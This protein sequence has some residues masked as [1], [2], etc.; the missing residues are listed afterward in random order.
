MFYGYSMISFKDELQ[1]YRLWLLLRLWSEVKLH[2]CVSLILKLGFNV[3][4]KG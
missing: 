1:C 3:D 4:V 2:F